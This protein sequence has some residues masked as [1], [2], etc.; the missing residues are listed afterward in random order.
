MPVLM[1]LLYGRMRSKTGS[2]TEGK[3]AAGTRMAIVLRFLAGSQ[4][5]EIHMYLDLL[6]EPVS[7]LKDGSCLAMV[8]QSV[9]QLDLS[10]FLPLGRQ[11]NIYNSLEV[12]LKNLGHLVLS[13]LPKILQILLCMTASVTQALEQRRKLQLRF[14]NPLKNL[15]RLGMKRII[16]FFRDFGTYPY[17]AEEIDA[18]FFAVVWP[19][20]RRIPLESQH[21]PSFVLQLIQVWSQSPRYHPLFAKTEIWAT[22]VR[23]AAKYICSAIYKKY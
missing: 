16:E 10:K 22:G 17:T 4:N 5:E 20:V 21:A 13:Y 18:V 2:K 12:A 1:R 23:C 19:N 6:Y 11:H 3:A 7:H 14:I 9:E 8:Q 15:R